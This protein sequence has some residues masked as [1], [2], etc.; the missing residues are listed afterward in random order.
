[1]SAT[2][3]KCAMLIPSRGGISKLFCSICTLLTDNSHSDKQCSS[4]DSGSYLLP[5][6]PDQE[7]QSNWTKVSLCNQLSDQ[8][9]YRSDASHGGDEPCGFDL[10]HGLNPLV[11]VMLWWLFR[12]PSVA[13]SGAGW[14]KISR[15]STCPRVATT[16]LRA[17]ATAWSMSAVSNIQKPPLCSLVSR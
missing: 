13:S 16:P 9:R 5:I 14:K 17:Q 8:C 10:P 11:N 2:V 3:R 12:Y 15:T 7:R 6:K 1:M 4:A